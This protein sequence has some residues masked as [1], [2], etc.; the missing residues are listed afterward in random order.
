MPTCPVS[1]LNKAAKITSLSIEHYSSFLPQNIFP[2]FFINKIY[3]TLIYKLGSPSAV[4]GSFD[5]MDCNPPGFINNGISQARI[6][7]Q[8]ANSYS[9][10]SSQPGDQTCISCISCIGRLVLYHCSTW[11]ARGKKWVSSISRK[12][13][14]KGK[15]EKDQGLEWMRHWVNILVYSFL[16]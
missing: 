6:L 3:Y 4:S 9:R 1:D 10:G 16:A 5:P 8:V 13:I 12:K 2:S 11:E 7:E 14:V 15:R